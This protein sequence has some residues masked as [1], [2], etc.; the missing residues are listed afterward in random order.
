MGSIQQQPQQNEA[1]SMSTTSTPTTTSNPQA[2]SSIQRIP[3]QPVQPAL[4]RGRDQG[5][6]IVVLRGSSPVRL[7]AIQARD[8]TKECHE[9]NQWRE[10]EK[11]IYQYVEKIKNDVFAAKNEIYDKVDE[12]S[13]VIFGIKEIKEKIFKDHL[14]TGIQISCLRDEM[15][16]ALK[17]L[18]EDLWYQ[19]DHTKFVKAMD[20]KFSIMEKKFDKLLNEPNDVVNEETSIEQKDEIKEIVITSIASEDGDILEKGLSAGEESSIENEVAIN[21]ENET[22]VISMQRE[23]YE[24]FI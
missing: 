16:D 12:F 23:K 22:N 14:T 1:T 24:N 13:E 18:R 9:H 6:S 8:L 17:N 19:C 3:P 15:K 11:K 10:F 21:D 7:G 4:S 20:S 5:K 2:A